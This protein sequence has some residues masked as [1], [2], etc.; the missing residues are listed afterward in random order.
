MRSFLIRAKK[1]VFNS[2][3][4]LLSASRGDGF[5]FEELREYDY[6]SDAKKIHWL[7]FARTQKLYQKEF[8]SERS[9]N[10]LIAPILTGSLWFGYEELLY[11]RVLEC[12]ALLGYSALRSKDRATLAPIIQQEHRLYPLLNTAILEQRLETLA[13][14]SL[15]QK[16]FSFD[17]DNFMK[18]PKSLIILIGDFLYKPNLRLI[19]LKHDVVAIVLRQHLYPYKKACEVVDNITLKKRSIYLSQRAVASYSHK[20][21]ALH[22]QLFLEWQKIG[23]DYTIIDNEPLFERLKL[24]FGRR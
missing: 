1:S 3:Q 18:L 16:E 7:S 17:F 6:Q 20:R 14:L 13:Q 15:V 23:V 4:G 2:Q 8:I 10:I 5:D 24:F 19:A 22:S 9:R 12:A 11:E 21:Q